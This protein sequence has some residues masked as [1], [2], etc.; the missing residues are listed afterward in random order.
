MRKKLALLVAFLLMGT[1]MSGCWDRGSGEK[2]GTIT[3]LN[4]VGTFC[5]TW[6]AEIIRGGLNTG[7]GVMG[8][9][10]HFTVESDE[11]AKDVEKYMNSQQEVKISYKME[12]VTF[13]RSERESEDHFLTKIEPLQ[14]VSTP[15]TQAKVAD[16][17]FSNDVLLQFLQKQN[18]LLQ[19]MLKKNKK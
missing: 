2:I 13:C 17:A 6:E 9:S 8:Q 16:G 18:E 11:L 7:S 10:F 12:L 1:L 14:V 3:R 19:E 5:K 15:P 4:R